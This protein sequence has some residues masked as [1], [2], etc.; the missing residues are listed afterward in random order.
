MTTEAVRTSASPSWTELL[1]APVPSTWC[2]C[3]TCCTAEVSDGVGWAVWG[4]A[5]GVHACVTFFSVSEPPTCSA[6]QFACTTGEIDCIPMAWRCDGYPECADG[7]DEDDCP[8]CSDRQFKC[9]RGGCIELQRRCD[10]EPDCT[11]QSDERDCKSRLR[12]AGFRTRFP[13]NGSSGWSSWIWPFLHTH[14]HNE[15]IGS[16]RSTWSH[17]STR[18]PLVPTTASGSLAAL[19]W[20]KAALHPRLSKRLDV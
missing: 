19:L 16:K 3:R 10:G 13:G 5:A 15:P 6:E 18:N 17:N 9:D 4:G 8:V 1:A 14:T 20:Q 11:D 7:S 2:C 12:L